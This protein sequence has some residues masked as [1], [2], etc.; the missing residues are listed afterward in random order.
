MFA[1]LAIARDRVPT[2]ALFL[3]ILLSLGFPKSHL[4]DRI[5]VL[6]VSLSAIKPL[7]LYYSHV[8]VV[9]RHGGKKHP[10]IFW[11]L[12]LLVGLCPWAMTLIS[13]SW[14]SSLPFSGRGLGWVDGR[15]VKYIQNILLTKVYSPNPVL[16][17]LEL[18]EQVPYYVY[19]I[20]LSL[21]Q[22][23]SFSPYMWL[24]HFELICVYGV[25]NEPYHPFH[26]FAYAYLVASVPFLRLFLLHWIVLAPLLKLN[27][28]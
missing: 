2:I 19:I 18:N 15:R 12:G 16:H 6:L 22:K 26:S 17:T 10:I 9:V 28:Q 20:C 23:S 14:L 11:N 1:V 25:K 3:S 5:Y 21:L 4:S 24:T 13:I 27:W 8:G 7:L